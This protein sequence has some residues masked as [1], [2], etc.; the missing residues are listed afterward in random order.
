MPGNPIDWTFHYAASF[1]AAL[2]ATLLITRT[3]RDRWAPRLGLVEVTMADGSPREWP[4]A[5]VGGIAMCAAIA[6]VA[7]AAT[8]LSPLPTLYPEEARGLIPVL[9][10]A[11]AMC[12]V[13][14]WDDLRD[15]SAGRK[16]IFQALIAAAVWYGGARFGSL[17]LPVFGVVELSPFASL[18][19]TVFWFVAITNA[20]NLVDGADGVAGGAALTATVAMFVV[21][22]VLKQPMAAQVLIVLAAALLGFLFFNFPPASVFMGDAGSLSIGFLLAGVGLVSSSKATTIAA[23]AIPVVSLGLPILDTGLAIVRRLLR[24][25]G[26]H[27][28][29]L[30]HVHHRLQKLGHSPRQVALILFAASGV[31][32]LASMVFLTPD[33]RVVGLVLL[34]IGVI[35][36]LAV[37]RLRIPELMELRRVMDRALRQREVIARSVAIREAVEAIADEITLDGI[38]RQVGLALRATHCDQAQ[39]RLRAD[40]VSGLDNER[41]VD[42]GAP[43]CDEFVWTWN[44]SEV[45]LIHPRQSVAWEVTVPLTLPEAPNPVGRLIVT[46][47]PVGLDPEDLTTIADSLR[48]ELARAAARLDAVRGPI[49]DRGAGAA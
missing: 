40:I 42:A 20:F 27:Q 7:V 28:R 31:L 39:F 44:Y 25:E 47:P 21:A 1:M 17:R 49:L 6:I 16:A 26:V 9:V 38:V 37:Q 46:R 45:P 33:L 19:F 22:L 3:V 14:L 13:G 32:A 48:G 36:L 30:G 8:V 35:T 18:A 23:I 2:V 4:A 34:V 41:T 29:D 11:L 15:L 5:K 24:G 43:E 12:G 10:G